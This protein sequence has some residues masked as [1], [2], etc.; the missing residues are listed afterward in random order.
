MDDT[1]ILDNILELVKTYALPGM[2]AEYRF[3]QVCEYIVG[4][5]AEDVEQTEKRLDALENRIEAVYS[6]FS[7]K[8]EEK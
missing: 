1:E 2:P 6:L 7:L 8:K 3:K 5:R 4:S